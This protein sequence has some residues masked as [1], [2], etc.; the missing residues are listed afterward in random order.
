MYPLSSVLVQI[1]RVSIR[2]C[3]L[4]TVSCWGGKILHME[5]LDVI[6]ERFLVVL[7]RE[8]IVCFF[9]MH[10]KR[11]CVILCVHR[12]RCDD[13]SLYVE[14]LKQKFHRGD[15]VALGI[16]LHLGNDD[17]I[18]VK[19]RGEEVDLL[20]PFTRRGL[21]GFSVNGY[22]PIFLTHGLPLKPCIN[23][24]IN[25]L[26]I[27]LT[28]KSPDGRLGRWHPFTGLIRLGTPEFRKH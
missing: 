4:S 18:V 13:C 1:L 9:F 16:H 15:L 2:P 6:V 11:R 27:G 14:R 24:L 7:D 28:Q 21:E 22:Y 20:L 8:E 25:C 5:G 12:I 19:K 3:P 17:L 26:H 10:D 23:R